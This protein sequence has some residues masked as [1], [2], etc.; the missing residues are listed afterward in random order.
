M[1]G[2]A[3]DWKR[4]VGRVVALLVGVAIG[5]FGAF[6]IVFSDAGSRAEFVQAVGMLAAVYFA[7]CFAAGV[8]GPKT[9]WEWGLW[10]GAPGAVLLVVYAF[11]ERAMLL[12]DVIVG[13]VSLSAA[14][15]GAALGALIRRM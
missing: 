4:I 1:W 15:V 7:V 13:T 3:V 8:I 6:N 11:M 9:G 10:I 2:A 12:N 5:F 14:C